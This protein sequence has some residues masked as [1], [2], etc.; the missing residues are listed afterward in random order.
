[1]LL[2]NADAEQRAQHARAEHAWSAFKAMQ[3]SS[4]WRVHV[5]LRAHSR[6]MLCIPC[7]CEVLHCLGC[8]RVQCLHMFVQVKTAKG[9]TAAC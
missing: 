5:Q 9:L 8:C 7:M 4:C 2:Q 1:M 3:C 6:C